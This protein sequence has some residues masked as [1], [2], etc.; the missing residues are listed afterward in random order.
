MRRSVIQLG[1]SGN[2]KWFCLLYLDPLNL[3]TLFRL[4][5]L[6]ALK[7]FLWLSNI[8]TVFQLDMSRQFD[9]LSR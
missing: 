4:F 6:F 8:L 3:F 2:I 5:D 7:D 9:V 1:T